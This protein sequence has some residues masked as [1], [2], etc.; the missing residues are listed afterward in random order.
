MTR[1][2]MAAPICREN[3]SKLLHLPLYASDLPGPPRRG[4]LIRLSS[5]ESAGILRR[6]MLG[7]DRETQDCRYRT[8]ILSSVHPMS[9]YINQ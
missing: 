1:N 9:G 3:K 2:W 8:N 6:P 4:S 5:S 7:K